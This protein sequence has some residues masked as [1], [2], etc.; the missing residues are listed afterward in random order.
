M[1]SPCCSRWRESIVGTS[2]SR[3]RL[4]TDGGQQILRVRRH[5]RQPARGSDERHRHGEI[6]DPVI[7][8]DVDARALQIVLR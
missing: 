3:G 2:P 4:T 7:G 5:Q 1:C 8:F 6:V